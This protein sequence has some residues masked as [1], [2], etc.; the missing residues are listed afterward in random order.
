[1]KIHEPGDKGLALC[2]SCGIV[3]TT[4]KFRETAGADG[5]LQTELVAACDVCDATIAAPAVAS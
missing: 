2:D 3:D 5:Q 1:M 4:F